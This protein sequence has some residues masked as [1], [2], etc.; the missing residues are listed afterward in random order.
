MVTK[1]DVSSMC[2]LKDN[3]IDVNGGITNA[4]KKAKLVC[5]F[6]TMIEVECRTEEDAFEACKAGAHIIMLDN[7][8]PE[9]CK[10]SAEKIKKEFPHITIEASGGITLKTVSGY[11]SSN[12][13]V[14][15]FGALT[16]G[17]PTVDMSLKIQKK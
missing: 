16:Q 17:F 10:K 2:M 5:G 1:K 15:S 7:F 3:H 8:E 9:K 13:D 14:I 6:T 4:V 12:I 11:L